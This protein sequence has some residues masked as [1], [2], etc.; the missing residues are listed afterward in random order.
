MKYKHIIWDWNGTLLND[1]SLCT[2]I[3]NESLRKRDIPEI[4][5][6]Q[7]KQKFLFPIKTFYESIGFDFDKEPFENSNNEFNAG[8]VDQFKS[9]ALQPFAKDTIIKFSE[10]K[11]TQTILSASRQDRLK[12]QVNFFDITQYLQHVVGTNNLYAHGKEYEGEELLL[13]LDIPAEE[14]IIIGDTLLDSS[15]AK[16][17]KID[18]ALVSNGH[19]DIKRLK[20]T[21]AFT[22]S[23]IKEFYNW[24]IT[25]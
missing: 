13:T 6:Q 20:E 3:L 1:T 10:K 8:F 19:N 16:Y 25:T 22:F 7:Y 23:D 21:G 11:I 14:T 9:L 15:V 2:Q 12:E 17:L 18:C 4:T 24:I 5:V